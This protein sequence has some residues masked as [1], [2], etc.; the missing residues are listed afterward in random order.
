MLVGLLVRRWWLTLV[1]IVLG[2]AAG[3]LYA[4][5]QPPKFTASQA[6]VVSG[7]APNPILVNLT[8]APE[9]PALLV[10]TQVD[11][12]EGQAVKHAVDQLLGSGRVT[13]AVSSSTASDVMTV[14]ATAGSALVARRG[15][16]AALASYRQILRS[17]QAQELGSVQATLRKSIAAATAAF[18]RARTSPLRSVDQQRIGSL[19]T[20]QAEL[21]VSEAAGIGVSQNIDGI[22][23]TG[24]T[25]SPGVKQ[26]GV[27]GA[28]LGLILAAII[29]V[30]TRGRYRPA[31]RRL[32]SA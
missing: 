8:T 7:L 2:A 3:V 29:L 11:I 21:T 31:S 18:R 10:Q 1:L 6:M 13:L 19:Q 27:I 4:H 25:V 30:A 17:E 12:L 14:S 23:A 20:T 5:K 9:D 24:P 28:V 32:R 26:G 16:D 15:I 22:Y